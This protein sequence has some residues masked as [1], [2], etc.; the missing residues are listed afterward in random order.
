MH[1]LS[2]SSNSNLQYPKKKRTK[3]YVYCT[4][5]R[6]VQKKTYKKRRTKRDV[7]RKILPFT[8]TNK[9]IQPK[10]HLLNFVFVTI[11]Q[12]HNLTISQHCDIISQLNCDKR[13]YLFE[14]YLIGKSLVLVTN[15]KILLVTN[16]KINPKKTTPK[17]Y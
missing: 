16:K 11:S 14:G 6:D 3:R 2:L 12:Y 1:E 9:K 8:K 10:N 4:P 5:K 7:P 17:K 15:Q 13:L